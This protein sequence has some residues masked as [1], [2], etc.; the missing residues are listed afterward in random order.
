MSIIQPLECPGK[1][2]VEI[3]LRG[4]VLSAD[5]GNILHQIFMHFRREWGRRSDLIIDRRVE[6]C[7]FFSDIENL[8]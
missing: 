8:A 2:D 4:I 7:S 1:V 3:V 5:P 6:G